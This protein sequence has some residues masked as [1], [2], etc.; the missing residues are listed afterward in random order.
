MKRVVI[1][2]LVSALI[3]SFSAVSFASPS[4][5]GFSLNV[6][7][8]S[9]DLKVNGTG[10]SGDSYEYSLTQGGLLGFDKKLRL[11][12]RSNSAYKLSSLEASVYHSLGSNL[13]LNVGGR[14]YNL[15]EKADGKSASKFT[16]QAGVEFRQKVDKNAYTYAS[17]TLGNNLG[18]YEVGLAYDLPFAT[19]DVNYRSEK[20]ENINLAGQKDVK[21]EGVGVG[22][23]VHF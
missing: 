8:R 2:M 20:I 23:T 13:Y 10:G 1:V 16:L 22:L 5:D 9:A 12:N 19:L 6:V 4:Q 14:N 3:A 17:A 11:A 21:N 15:K 7:H 18:D